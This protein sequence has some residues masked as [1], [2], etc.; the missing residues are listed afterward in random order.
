MNVILMFLLQSEKCL[1]FIPPDG[2]FRLISYHLGSGSI[3]AIPIYVKPMIS[4]K[5][6]RVDISVG[7]KQTMGRVVENVVV[8]VPFPK[9]V[10]NCNL[11][12]SQGKYSFDPVSKVM[13]WEVGKIDTSKN[14]VPTIRGGVSIVGV[15][16]L[17]QPLGLFD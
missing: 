13:T 8:E 16:L 6:G 1:S 3:V 12:P 10:L 4:F 2:N 14:S 15:L 5:E 11:T 9:A 17:A 7:P